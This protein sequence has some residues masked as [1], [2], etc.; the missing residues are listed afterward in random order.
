MCHSHRGRSLVYIWKYGGRKLAKEVESCKDTG[1]QILCYWNSIMNIFV[2]LFLFWVHIQQ[3]SNV[4]P[5]SALK[6][7]SWWFVDNMRHH[8][9]NLSFHMW[10]KHPTSCSAALSLQLCNF[11]YKNNSVKIILWIRKDVLIRIYYVLCRIQSDWFDIIIFKV[12]HKNIYY[13]SIF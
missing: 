4:I 6:R 3:S 8:G 7:H 12:T 9:L 2:I 10:R 1:T 11:V 5:G 13:N